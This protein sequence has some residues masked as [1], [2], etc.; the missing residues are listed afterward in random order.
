MAAA[1]PDVA[2]VRLP[3]NLGFA[4]G[5]NAGIAAAPLATAPR[6]SCC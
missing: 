2:L 3:K 4:G 5:M 1:Y 6:P